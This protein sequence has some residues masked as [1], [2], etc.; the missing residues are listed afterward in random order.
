MGYVTNADIEERLGG[1]QYVQLTDDEGTGQAD[2]DKVDEARLGAEGEV[3]SYIGRRY[4]VP[5]DLSR[6]PELADVLR[7][8]VLDLVEYRLHARRPPVPPDIIRK[9]QSALQWLERVARG[10]IVLPATSVV[11]GNTATGTVGESSTSRRIFT[12]DSLA[13]L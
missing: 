6:Y 2:T 13:D 9:R 3:N 11:T 10:E 12:R 8:I 1:A 5:V 7:S 4:A